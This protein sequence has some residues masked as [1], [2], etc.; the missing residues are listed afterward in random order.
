MNATRHVL[1]FFLQTARDESQKWTDTETEARSGK[2][3]AAQRLRRGSD[4]LESNTYTH[5]Q[6]QGRD[7]LSPQ[8]LRKCLSLATL[9]TSRVSTRRRQR[10]EETE[11]ERERERT[12]EL[13]H[14]T[15]S[16][17]H[18]AAIL[19]LLYLRCC[20]RCR[21]RRRRCRKTPVEIWTQHSQYARNETYFHMVKTFANGGQ[22]YHRLPVA[23]SRSKAE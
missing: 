1:F 19:S 7:A 18:K 23:R 2:A 13:T 21:R 22:S 10:D 15:K 9:T 16:E 11:R 12:V 4:E 3:H 17:Q 6:T 5:T 8:Q 20:R 14:T